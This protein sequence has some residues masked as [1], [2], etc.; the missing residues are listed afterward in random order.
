[1]STVG[2]K[3]VP[4]PMPRPTSAR[5]IVATIFLGV[6]LAIGGYFGYNAWRVSTAET[7]IQTTVSACWDSTLTKADYARVY[8]DARSAIQ[9]V[10]N[11][12]RRAMMGAKLN[13]ELIRAGCKVP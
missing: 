4:A 6:A 2:F 13:N 11:I 12:D 5:A 1:M 8:R 7:A 9:A 10:P 3:A